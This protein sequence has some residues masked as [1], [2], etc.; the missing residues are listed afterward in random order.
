[1][2]SSVAGF[3]LWQEMVKRDIGDRPVTGD[4]WSS[5]ADSD[6]VIFESF[7]QDREV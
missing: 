7:A 1:M 2:P 6:P 5:F 4:S 3:S